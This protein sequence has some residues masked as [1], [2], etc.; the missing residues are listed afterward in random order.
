MSKGQAEIKITVLKVFKPEEVFKDPP[1]KTKE[2]YP[3][4][5]HEEGQT[6][7]V[8]GYNQPEG[9]CGFAWNV[10]WP[11][12][13]M[14]RNNSDLIWYYEKPGTLVCCCPDGLRPVV[15]KLERV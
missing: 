5:I 2:P 9:M 6:F 10:I 1:I 3:C 13:M 11:F 14:L 8:K 7:I 4:P 15:F 12:S